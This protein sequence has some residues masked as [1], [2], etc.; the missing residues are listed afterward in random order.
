MPLIY[1]W[2]NIVSTLVKYIASKHVNFLGE[3]VTKQSGQVAALIT[4]SLSDMKRTKVRLNG[5]IDF[6]QTSS[7]RT[8]QGAG[9]FRARAL[10]YWLWEETHDPKVVGSN[11]STINWMDIFSDLLVV[12]IV[13][14]VWKDEIN[15][16]ETG[17]G[18]FKKSMGIGCGAVGRAVASD[19]WHCP[20]TLF[21]LCTYWQ[22]HII[23]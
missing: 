21:L 8:T 17:D 1:D 4:L 5:A 20:M 3:K 6:G 22:S 16:K 2:P 10:V 14:F 15:E 23:R 9:Q 11:P 7:V 13:L 12:K 19:T 18:T